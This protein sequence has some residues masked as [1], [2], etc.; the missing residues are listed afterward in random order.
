MDASHIVMVGGRGLLALLFILAG[1]TKILGP[2]PV[3]DHM[4]VQ[5]IPTSTFALVVALELVA[6]LALMIGWHAPLAAGA[7]AGFCVATA[8][9]VHRDLSVRAERTQFA[10]DLALAGA[11]AFI[12]AA[13]SL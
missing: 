10:K 3:L 12:A 11:L 6:G 8:I 1:I 7:L 13:T 9:L 2:K 5:G 4:R